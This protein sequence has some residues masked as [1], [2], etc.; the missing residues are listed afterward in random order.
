MNNINKD[1]IKHHI[2]QFNSQNNMYNDSKLDK[3]CWKL[4]IVG[5]IPRDDIYK[6][7][8]MFNY[9][10]SILSESS[11]R[12]KLNLWINMNVNSTGYYNH[13][14]IDRLESDLGKIAYNF[15]NV[16]LTIV[17]EKDNIEYT[18]KIYDGKLKS[19]KQRF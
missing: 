5:I 9:T 3:N 14:H 2:L 7:K 17:A 1:H 15:K 11:N 6:I 10:Q 16:Y 8:N 4:D 18:Y 12:K 13:I 19:Y